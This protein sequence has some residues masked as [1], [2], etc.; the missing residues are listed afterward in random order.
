MPGFESI[1]RQLKSVLNP[2]WTVAGVRRLLASSTSTSSDESECFHVNPDTAAAECAKH[3]QA[4]PTAVIRL[5]LNPITPDENVEIGGH[6]FPIAPNRM[7][8]TQRWMWFAIR[9]TKRS[10][11][12]DIS[13]DSTQSIPSWAQNAFHTLSGIGWPAP[14]VL[15]SD[16]ILTSL[17]WLDIA[18]SELAGELIDD[19]LKELSFRFRRS[20]VLIDASTSNVKTTC[21]LHAGGE[22]TQYD[23]KNS[24]V[25]AVQLPSA[26]PELPLDRLHEAA[27]RLYGRLFARA[28]SLK[29]MPG[30]RQRLDLQDVLKLLQGVIRYDAR[31]KARC[32]AHMDQ[33]PSLSVGEGDDGRVLLYCHA[34]CKFTDVCD[35]L[36]LEPSQLL[37]SRTENQIAPATI[38]IP[39]G[40]Y[41]L[42]QQAMHW[43]AS[44]TDANLNILSVQ[45]GVSLCAL[46]E[47][48]VGWSYEH[49]AWTIPERRPDGWVTGIQL[50]AP[51][52]QK[53]MVRGSHRGLILP[54]GWWNFRG[55]VFIP[56]GMSDVAALR[57]YGMAAIGRPSAV[58]G[59]AILADLL[60]M[61]ALSP[62]IVGENDQKP[63]GRWPGREGAERCAQQLAAALHRRVDIQLP[64]P[65][66]K[67]IREMILFRTEG[68]SHDQPI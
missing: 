24:L 29:V 39:D 50:R 57:S 45:L 26:N 38:Q 41:E 20:D 63:D 21:T 66:R 14:I 15:S 60:K 27:N 48:E 65:G 58:G 61:S 54:F 59:I 8:T 34:G 19:T 18:D 52:G 4:N 28:S 47:L 11:N 5:E 1:Q 56:E 46:R 9:F 62:I 37:P 6:F 13:V 2:I 51:D 49:G 40:S 30:D 53:R 33:N 32:P 68:I 3:I 43:S 17:F 55:Q 36:G 25:H 12:A 22:V 67:D 64:P 44:T 42:H 23:G 35:S 7:L 16:G 31:Y 10:K